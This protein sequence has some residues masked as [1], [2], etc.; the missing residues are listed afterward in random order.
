MTG[1]QDL[2][3]FGYGSLMWEPGFPFAEAH[4][5]SLP[6]YHREFCIYSVHY[7]GTAQRPGLVLGLDRGGLCEGIA[8]RVDAP[9]RSR[10]LA[11]L[12]QRELIYGVYREAHLPI[13]LLAE[14]SRR[15]AALT[16][17]AER[18]HPSYAGLHTPRE[19]AAL[20]RSAAGA[21]G[22]NLE[23]LV[24]TLDRMSRLGIRERGLERLLVLAGV[25]AGRGANA[26]AG[27]RMRGHAIRAHWSRR[28]AIAA[29]IRPEQR[30]RFGHRARLAGLRDGP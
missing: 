27:L 1:A 18:A 2:W 16:Y 17:V 11:Y 20:I 7:R 24:N 23:Y 13:T 30:A 29:V 21:A 19:Q 5:A 26:D 8:Y 12:R 15:L 9:D 3:V 4:H 10:V 14:G 22:S 6:G 25:L 28:P